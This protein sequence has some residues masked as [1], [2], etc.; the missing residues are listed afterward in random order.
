MN[1]YYRPYTAPD[2]VY[3]NQSTLPTNLRAF[4]QRHGLEV[5]GEVDNQ[6]IE[7]LWPKPGGP[8]EK[9]LHLSGFDTAP[10][11]CDRYAE[12][13]TDTLGADLLPLSPERMHAVWRLISSN[14][15]FPFDYYSGLFGAE[16]GFCRW[17]GQRLARVLN[18]M[19][20]SYQIGLAW[21]RLIEIKRTE[22]NGWPTSCPYM[23]SILLYVAQSRVWWNAQLCSSLDAISDL[24]ADFPKWRLGRTIALG[25]QTQALAPGWLRSTAQ[26]DA[27]AWQDLCRKW[28]TLCDGE[29]RIRRTQQVI[30]ESERWR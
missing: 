23:R 4:Q 20:G 2:H 26:D 14:W 30:R 16:M 21:H 22:T 9:A 18:P 6:T 7:A 27:M 17:S 5:T 19:S 25:A 24:L 11:F 10:E 3:R 8:D 13:F 12:R 1:G 15:M 28:D 29:R